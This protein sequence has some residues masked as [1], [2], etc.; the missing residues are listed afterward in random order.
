MK[1]KQSP[2]KGVARGKQPSEKAFRLQAKVYFLTY[3][4]G[5]G[6]SKESLVSFLVHGNPGDR[7]VRPEKY[8]VCAQTYASGQPH[9]HAILVYPRRKVVQRP[10]HYDFQGVHPHIQTMRNMKAALAYV[11]KQD[12]AP[13]S[14]MDLAQQD[15]VARAKDTSSLFDLLY[16]QMKKDPLGFDVFRYCQTHALTRQI[17]KANYTKAV[18][19]IRQV[20][21]VAANALLSGMPGLRPITRQ[22]IQAQLTHEQLKTYDSWPGYAT[23]VAFLNTM[24][25]QRGAR[26][27]KSLNLLLTGPPGTGKS[28]LVW[29]RNPLPGRSSI[30]SHC[31]VYPMGM[32]DWFP[33]YRSDVYHAIYWNQ[34]KLTSYSQDI[35]LQLLDGSPVLLPAKGGGHKKVDN[36]LVVMTSNMTL[37]QMILV[38]FGYNRH[39]VALARANLAARVT[40][41]VIPQGYTLFL[42]Q[43]L[44]VPRSDPAATV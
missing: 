31:S 3:A 34:A 22:F 13:L 20:Q 16:A 40:N 17:Y 25:A 44:L 38:K 24:T 33:Q 10:D 43:K 5:P 2:K 19:L 28:A 39:Y 26:Q 37:D 11:V 12:A 7:S 14:N 4:G 36:P 9:Y 1:P 42:L 21:P 30:A 29:Q 6:I 27:Q 8:L 35:I 23:I 32:R 15:R 18:R 41:V